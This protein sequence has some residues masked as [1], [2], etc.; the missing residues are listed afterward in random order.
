[1]EEGMACGG[2]PFLGTGCPFPDVDNL[3]LLC[4]DFYVWDAVA[5]FYG[6]VEGPP[7]IFISTS[8]YLIRMT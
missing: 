1:M 5:I 2:L 3:C 6:G 8:C 7:H 4:I